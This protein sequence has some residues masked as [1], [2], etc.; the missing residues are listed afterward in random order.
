MGASA[1]HAACSKRNSETEAMDRSPVAQCEKEGMRRMRKDSGSKRE[2]N[3]EMQ[4]GK[5][6]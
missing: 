3:Q 6:R 4:A 5:E 1:P 2:M